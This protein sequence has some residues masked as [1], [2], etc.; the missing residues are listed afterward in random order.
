MINFSWMTRRDENGKVVLD[1][2]RLDDTEAAVSSRADAAPQ[3]SAAVAAS[4]GVGVRV[5]C[6][7]LK[8]G[9]RLRPNCVFSK[10]RTPPARRKVKGEEAFY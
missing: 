6:G 3:A 10:T 8:L 2:H 9:D 4:D 7:G 1:F 5:F